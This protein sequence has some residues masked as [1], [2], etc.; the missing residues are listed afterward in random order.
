[1]DGAGN[2]YI[3]D[4]GNSRIRKVDASGTITTVAGNGQPLVLP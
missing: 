1:V 4:T 2:V 3:A